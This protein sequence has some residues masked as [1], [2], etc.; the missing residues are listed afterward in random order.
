MSTTQIT[1]SILGKIMHHQSY[2]LYMDAA[3]R[4]HRDPAEGPALEY[5]DNLFVNHRTGEYGKGEKHW[6]VQGLHHREDGP[7]I[8]RFVP[9]YEEYYIE[10][11]RY[12]KEEW[13]EVLVL[14]GISLGKP[15]ELEL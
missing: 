8:T 10:G 12:S 6:K 15:V 4:Q 9:P 3:G 14:R 5:L 1:G 7:A 11:I 2:I 13:E